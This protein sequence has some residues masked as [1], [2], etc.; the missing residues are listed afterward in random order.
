MPTLAAMVVGSMVGAGVFSLPPGSGSPR[1]RPADAAPARGRRGRRHRVHAVPVRGGGPGVPAAV[2]AGPRAADPA[3]REARSEHGR[4]LSTP[5]EAVLCG[6]V[7]LGAVIAVLGLGTGRI[8][9]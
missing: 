3:L 8:E 9:L 4:R 1:R 7:V 6:V 2:D 5:T